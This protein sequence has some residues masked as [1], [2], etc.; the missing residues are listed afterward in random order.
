MSTNPPAASA[1]PTDTW[2]WF[3]VLGA[4][5]TLLGIVGVVDLTVT[6]LLTAYG[7]L[8]FGFLFTIAGVAQI[9][10]GLFV[11]PWASAILQILCGVLYVAAGGFTITEP[12]LFETVLTLLLA[13]ALIFGGAF[14][15]VLAFLQMRVLAWLLLAFAG[16]VTM[17]VGIMILRRWPWDS[18]WVIGLFFAIDLIFQGSSW[19][20]L[21]VNLRALDRAVRAGVPVEIRNQ[22]V[23][24]AAS[25]GVGVEFKVENLGG[26]L[27]RSKLMSASEMQAM[28]ERSRAEAKDPAHVPAFLRW[29][30]AKNY[31]TEYQAGLLSRGHVDD[32][33]LGQYKILERI[34]RGRMAGVYRAVHSSGQIVA[35]KV[36]PPSRA[37]NGQILARFQREARLAVKLKNPHV[38]RAFQVGE[39]RGVHYLV[40]ECL[41]GETLD[42]VLQRRKRLPPGEAV[43][44]IH[45]ALLGLQHIHEQGMVHRD[46]KPANLMLFPAPAVG[47]NE[48]TAKSN[49]KILDIGLARE[50]FDENSPDMAEKM[51]LTGEGV[52]LGT[53]DYLAPEQAR[54]PRSIDIRADIYS[55]GCTLYHLIT[56]QP[57]FP[58]KNILNQMIRHA[59]EAPKPMAEF[60]AAIPEGLA[61]IADWMMAKQPAQRYPTPARAAQALDAFLMV[62]ADSARPT[63]ESPQMRKY[64]TWLEIADKPGEDADATIPPPAIIPNVP[65]IAAAPAH[66]RSNP[67][68]QAAPQRRKNRTGGKVAEPAPVAP[69][70]AVPLPADPAPAANADTFDVELVDAP[71]APVT[72]P[73]APA[74]A[75]SLD[76]HLGKRD[77]IMLGAGAGVMLIIVLLCA[78]ARY[79]FSL[80]V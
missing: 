17:L 1:L 77:F 35:I 44:L 13:I 23:K 29:L 70:V 30:V 24:R 25:E 11:R 57:P 21:G 53:P 47:E 10:G 22:R 4:I 73:L 51:E 48:T 76:K 3:I 55:L 43:R 6:E 60:N 68:Q 67:V 65:K 64:L 72:A 19:L 78:G 26:F 12:R 75:L 45:Q 31:L 63:E 58:D 5:C 59:T 40:M 41:E 18:T 56:G 74:K 15:V 46:L 52:L 32:F 80:L 27:I 54:D 34:G 16:I 49:V 39:A 36:L 61:Q 33:F 50:F 14:R 79:L 62:T 69:A 2:I 8:L 7:V 37:K 28:R 38:V 20:A 66:A 71:P 42:E 9:I